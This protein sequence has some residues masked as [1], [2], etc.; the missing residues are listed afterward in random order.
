M[1]G[2]QGGRQGRGARGLDAN[3]ADLGV[4]EL[5]EGRDAAGQAAAAHGHEDGIDKGQ[6]LDDLHGD[7]A[8]AGGH[9][10]VVEGRDVG[11]AALFGQLDGAGLGVVKDVAVQDDLGAVA[12]GAVD[13]DERR[14][15]GHDHDR[16]G[17][18]V[19]G[20][21]GDALGVVA[22]AGGDDAA[23]KL[24]LGKL[25]DLVVGAAQLVGAGALHVLGL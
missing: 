11:Q 15:G 14:G 1:A 19:G 20:R 5:G 8:L 22:G 13:L 18:R 6:L 24:F 21:V 10:G 9:T 16:A 12:L 4:V 17:A 25:R 3:D 7:G 2:V 23:V